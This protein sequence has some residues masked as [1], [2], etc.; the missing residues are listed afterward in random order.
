RAHPLLHA[1][2]PTLDALRAASK[3]GVPLLNSLDP[4]ITRM[5]Q[6]LLPYLGTRDSGTGLRV[7]ES[8]GPF[9]SSISSAASE[10]DS[11]GHR[12][13]LEVAPSLTGFLTNSPGLAMRV[14]CDRSRI[15]QAVCPRL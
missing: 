6:E 1:A 4:T 10:Y 11:I 5:L 12:I 15:P 8:I 7:F 2:G 14:R 13:R 3:V 9:F